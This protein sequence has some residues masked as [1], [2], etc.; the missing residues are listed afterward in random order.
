IRAQAV[1]HRSHHALGLDGKIGIVIQTGMAHVVLNADGEVV[2]D[3]G[4]GLRQVV[5]NGCDHRG[6]E[7]FGREAVTST[8]DYRRDLQRSIAQPDSLVRSRTA[9]WRTVGGRASRNRWTENG[10]YRR[11]F[12]K[13]TFSPGLF[14]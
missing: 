7:F 9:I 14:R 8:D 2:L 13:P 1:E 10:R 4:A 5:V 11:T 3:L 12:S 6:C